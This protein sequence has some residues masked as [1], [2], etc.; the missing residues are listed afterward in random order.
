MLPASVR[1]LI[2]ADAI[3]SIYRPDLVNRAQRPLRLLDDQPSCHA[4]GAGTTSRSRIRS[5]SRNG[6]R[7]RMPRPKREAEPPELHS[8]WSKFPRPHSFRQPSLCSGFS[9]RDRDHP[10]CIP[11]KEPRP[12]RPQSRFLLLLRFRIAV[13]AP[14]S[15]S[16][17]RLPVPAPASAP[18][19]VS[20]L[21]SGLRRAQSSPIEASAHSGSRRDLSSRR[22]EN[23]FALQ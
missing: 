21:R 17:L 10:T 13:P 3:T 16:G 19:L 12:H 20:A 2:A 23:G 14:C 22:Q 7:S 5:R 18:A 1:P 8:K 6:F 15:G 4:A 9:N 11:P